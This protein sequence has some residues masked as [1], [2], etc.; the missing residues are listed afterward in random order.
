[1][2][3]KSV[4][5][6]FRKKGTKLYWNSYRGNWDPKPERCPGVTDPGI[7][8]L[9]RKV[10]AQTLIGHKLAAKSPKHIIPVMVTR[11]RWS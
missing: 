1:M 8:D 7:V 3:T 10:I 2:R 9:M 11:T 6:H 4:Y 5:W